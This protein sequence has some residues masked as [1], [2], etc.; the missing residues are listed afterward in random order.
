MPLM[1]DQTKVGFS[2][3]GLPLTALRQ[4]YHVQLLALLRSR[5]MRRDKRI[6]ECLKVGSPPLR[7]GVCNLPVPVAR[8]LASAWA[9]TLVES[10]F[11][12]CDLFVFGSEVV[13]RTTR[14][15]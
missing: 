8:L 11:E 4:L 6:H 7:E 13:T 14:M 1:A 2:T 3:Y 15:C 9:E 12:T 5:D 10:C